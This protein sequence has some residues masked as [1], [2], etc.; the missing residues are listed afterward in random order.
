MSEQSG[1]ERKYEEFYHR[2]DPVHVYPVEFVVRAFLGSY[3][4]H[5]LDASAYP[6]KRVLD[7]GYGD[8]R[9]MPLLHNLGFDI[10]GVEISD[11]IN[12]LARKRMA[13]L[14]IPVTLTVGSNAHIPYADGFFDYLLACHACYYIEPGTTFDTNLAEIT[15]VLRPGGWF[16]ASVP[17]TSTYI[18][19]GAEP[20]GDGH[21]RITH[22]PY[23]VRN[24]TLFRAFASPSEIRRTLRPRYRDLRIGSCNN[25]FFGIREKVWIIVGQRA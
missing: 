7:L 17:M 18:L 20:L 8:G 19:K 14:Q 13:R 10:H 22:D 4:R 1:I 9:N 25:D 24:G 12:A 23:G 2:R 21:F 11:D 5:K 3:P 6:G 15:R 16:I